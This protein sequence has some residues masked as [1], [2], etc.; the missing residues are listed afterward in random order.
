MLLVEIKDFKAL[1]GNKPFFHQCIKDKQEK[2]E[3]LI[4][5][6]R[7]DDYTNGNLLV[8]LTVKIIINLLL[9]IYQDK[10]NP[11]ILQKVNSAGKLE[12]GDGAAIFFIAEK[13]EKTI[14]DFF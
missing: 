1:I 11:S 10:K 13:Q 14:S 4:K 8:Y 12:E 3:K 5:M 6:T 9:Q 7:N 2:H